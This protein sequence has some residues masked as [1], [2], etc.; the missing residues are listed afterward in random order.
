MQVLFYIILT[1]VIK[2]RQ[3]KEFMFWLFSDKLLYGEVLP[4]MT[5][6]SYNLNRTIVLHECCIKDEAKGVKERAECAFTVESPAKSFV[7]WAK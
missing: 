4:G 7:I 5:G 6:N 2:R 3:I 1:N